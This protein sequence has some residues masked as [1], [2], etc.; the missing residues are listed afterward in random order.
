MMKL[1]PGVNFTNIF[2][3]SFYSNISQKH[4]RD[5]LVISAF[6]AF[7]ICARKSCSQM[8][9]KLTPG[10]ETTENKGVKKTMSSI[11]SRK[12]PTLPMTHLQKKVEKYTK[13]YSPFLS[14]FQKRIFCRDK[15]LINR[16]H[17]VLLLNKNNFFCINLMFLLNEMK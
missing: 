5:S 1:T 17:Y 9:V 15:E 6:C 4:K 11:R 13:K 8:L 7:G 2:T 14:F 12:G 3:S 10:R 16:E